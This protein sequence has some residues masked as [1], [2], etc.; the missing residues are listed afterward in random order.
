LR[1]VQAALQAE[2]DELRRVREEAKAEQAAQAEAL[3][4]AAEAANSDAKQIDELRALLQASQAEATAKGLEAERL[5][6][7]LEAIGGVPDAS[8]VDS[9][10]TL[11]ERLKEAGHKVCELQIALEK[12][13]A[14]SKA[15]RDRLVAY[16]LSSLASLR[17]HLVTTLTGTAKPGMYINGVDAV[18]LLMKATLKGSLSR[19]A[20]LNEGVSP[21]RSRVG[22]SSLKPSVSLPAIPQGVLP[23]IAMDTASSA[24]KSKPGQIQHVEELVARRASQATQAASL[25]DVDDDDDDDESAVLG[26]AATGPAANHRERSKAAP[27]PAGRDVRNAIKKAK[28]QGDPLYTVFYSRL[29]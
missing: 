6:R 3:T 26:G 24:A 19:A 28:A 18:P 8:G 10:A 27:D 15:D 22:A 20:N 1:S 23:A 7:S 2:S 25:R 12:L 9:S 21:S 16:S 13:Q 11:A 14:A 29:Y 4:S 17:T 5:V